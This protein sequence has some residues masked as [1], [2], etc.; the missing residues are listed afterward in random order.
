MPRR[1]V[2]RTYATAF[3]TALDAILKER[4]LRRI[5]VAAAASLNISYLSN[6]MTGLKKVTP[7]RVETLAATIGASPQQ[8][9]Q[10]HRAAAQDVGYVLDLTSDM[11]TTPSE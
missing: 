2:D 1:P 6:M 10:L 5:D 11:P 7:E 8:R 3:G 4:K 9:V